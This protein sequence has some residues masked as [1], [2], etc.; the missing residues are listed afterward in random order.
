MHSPK[1]CLPGAGWDISGHQEIALTS[2]GYRDV[3]NRYGIQ[4]G[5][6][7]AVTL[8]WYQSQDRIVASEYKAKLVLAYDSICKGKTDGSLVRIVFP[9]GA[10]QERA[11]EDFAKLMIPEMRR[12]LGS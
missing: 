4:K 6:Q 12:C 8:Y 2:P 5:A 3:I 11:A 9:E 7:H 1:H 10:E